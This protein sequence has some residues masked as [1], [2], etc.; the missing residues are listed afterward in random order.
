PLVLAPAACT[1]LPT[2]VHNG[3]PVAVGFLLIFGGD[4]ERESFVVLERGPSVEADAGNPRN[5]EFDHQY[6][7]FLA[8]RIVTGG[9]V[10]GIHLAVGKGLGIE[11]GSRFRVLV[12]PEADRVL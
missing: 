10:Y 11:A 9:T 5:C 8:G 7:A 12:V 2:I 6:V 4:L 1:L 3:I